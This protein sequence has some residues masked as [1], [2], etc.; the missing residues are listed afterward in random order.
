M[1]ATDEAIRLEV[2]TIEAYSY[3]RYA[4]GEWARIADVLLAL[5]YDE[6]G[7]E[8]FLMSKHMRWISDNAEVHGQTTAVDFARYIGD[9]RTI[10]DFHGSSLH[11]EIEYLKMNS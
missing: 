11:G 3:D 6:A 5:G 2:K 8:A 4:P 7:I 1:N 10:R 9:N